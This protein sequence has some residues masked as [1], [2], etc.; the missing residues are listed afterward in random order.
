MDSQNNK[1]ENMEID[2]LELVRQLWAKR[3]YI[4]KVTAVAMITGLIVAFSIP[5]EY[6]CTVKMA[7][8]GS[9]SGITGDMSSIAAMAGINIGMDDAD[10]LSY[11]LYPDV[12]QSIP[13]IT[14]LINIPINTEELAVGSNL[15]NYI[16]KEI[17]QPWWEAV[18]TSPFKL[19]DIIHYGNNKGKDSEINPYKLTKKQDKI[20][21]S[22]KKRISVNIDKKT[23]IITTG[24]TLQDQALAAVV[25]DSLVSKLER[26]VID[27]R[28]NKAKQDLDFAL[29]V[30]TDSKQKY[31]DAQ[32]SY[33]RYID[34]NKNI[35]LES[36]LIEQER[37]KNEQVLAYNVYSGL[38][39]Q[40]EKARMKVQEQ[41]PCVTVIEPARVPVRKSN[42]SKV[43]ILL[44]FA[45]I[46]CLLGSFRVI[47]SKW[48]KIYVTQ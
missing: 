6:T 31:Y 41:T 7:P 21:T 12:V 43:V 24:V 10:G 29:K 48:D 39:Q 30:F 32:K 2:L 15:Y 46:G 16:D 19:M 28:T 27:Y 20:F 34:N 35:V 45:I 22:L 36:V 3:I 8:E 9:K 17:R 5:R 18:L 38:A 14:E 37:L 13:F 23:G 33:A 25:A 44:V 47:Y 40:V 1:N 42:T 11:M 26:F 4:L